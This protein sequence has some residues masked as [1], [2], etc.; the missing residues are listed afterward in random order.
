M[1]RFNLEK[2]YHFIRF[3]VS[4]KH[5]MG[6]D[7]SNP[8]KS[9]TPWLYKDTHNKPEFKRL[10]CLEHHKVPE[11]FDP[12]QEPKYDGFRFVCPQEIEGVTYWDNQYPTA[13]Y[14]QMSDTA[15]RIVSSV[16][17][18]DD[19][20]G[21]IADIVEFYL[22]DNALSSMWKLIAKGECKDD[23]VKEKIQAIFKEVDAYLEHEDVGILISKNVLEKCTL[24]SLE[25]CEANDQTISA[26]QLLDIQWQKSWI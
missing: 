4:G 9:I 15:D 21:Q 25:I 5:P 18:K 7:I 22:L 3:L 26:S 17:Y 13:S 16:V 10:L 24:V 19:N 23:F 12:K 20:S 6:N 2:N 8:I 14:G 1:S 11:E